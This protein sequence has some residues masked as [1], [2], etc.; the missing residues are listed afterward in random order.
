MQVEYLLC[1]REHCKPGCRAADEV[2]HFTSTSRMQR[3]FL[4]CIL[5]VVEAV[6][7]VVTVIIIIIII[8]ML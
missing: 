2:M 7:V 8:I 1:Q 5:I 6:V 4:A 3:S